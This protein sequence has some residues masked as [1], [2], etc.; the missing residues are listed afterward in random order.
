TADLARVRAQT[1]ALTVANLRQVASMDVFIVGQIDLEGNTGRMARVIRRRLLAESTL[2][3][4]PARRLAP[5]DGSICLD[6]GVVYRLSG[7]WRRAE[8]ILTQAAQLTPGSVD[9]WALLALARAHRGH[10]KA[11]NEAM[12]RAFERFGQLDEQSTN[13]LIE[14]NNLHAQ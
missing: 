10:H 7:R 13:A 14:T 5:E 3:L 8:A 9:A 11:A 4:R 12:Q 2:R 6:L 1:R